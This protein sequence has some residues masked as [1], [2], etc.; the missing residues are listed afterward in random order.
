MPRMR[1][2]FLIAGLTTLTLQTGCGSTPESL[3]IT[4]PAPQVQPEMAPNDA[5]VLPP[6]LPDPNTSSGAEQRYYRYN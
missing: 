2:L 1:W 5:T 6:G 4:G 3:G